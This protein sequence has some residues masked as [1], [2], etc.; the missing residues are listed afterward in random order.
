MRVAGSSRRRR[1]SALLKPSDIE[2]RSGSETSAGGS[3]RARPEA[4][5][6]LLLAGAGAEAVR[7]IGIAELRTGCDATSLRRARCDGDGSRS[8]V[9]TTTAG[10]FGGVARVCASSVGRE[11]GD[12]LGRWLPLRP[13]G[14]PNS[15][16]AG[17]CDPLA[18]AAGR[19]CDVLA[20]TGRWAAAPSARARCDGPEPGARDDVL[21]DAGRDGAL[22]GGALGGCAALSGCA[23]LSEGTRC[24][25]VEALDAL[26]ERAGCTDVRCAGDT[27]TAGSRELGLGSAS[28]CSSG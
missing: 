19:C 13:F 10:M 9:S 12:R 22:S 18:E 15:R 1:R 4:G 11:V 7:A 3:L 21:A 8:F 6:G 2:P 26:D 17:R 23:G 14:A 28:M 5:L 20:V 24:V 25:V 27:S 16:A